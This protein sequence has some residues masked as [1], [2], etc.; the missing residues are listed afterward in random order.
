[1]SSLGL[2]LGLAFELLNC[3]PLKAKV[4]YFIKV[5]L[6]VHSLVLII[7]FLRFHTFYMFILRR[8]YVGDD[9][10]NTTQNKKRK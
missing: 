7:G 6:F 10:I 1:M 8:K 9:Y 3:H 5:R 2:A 4:V